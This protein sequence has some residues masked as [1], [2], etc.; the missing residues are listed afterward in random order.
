MAHA[1]L[2]GPQSAIRPLVICHGG[3]ADFGDTAH[4]IKICAGTAVEIA[5]TCSAGGCPG[6]ALPTITKQV[7]GDFCDGTGCSLTLND[8]FKYVVKSVDGKDT[9]AVTL[10]PQ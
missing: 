4:R 10:L 2:P 6:G 9:D 7:N 8:K 1:P 3:A 5:I